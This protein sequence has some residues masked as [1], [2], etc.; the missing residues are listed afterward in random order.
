V[1]N[2]LRD[3]A[4][5]LGER[6]HPLLG[7]IFTG[8]QETPETVQACALCVGDDARPADTTLQDK[9]GHTAYVCLEHDLLLHRAVHDL[10]RIMS[11]YEAEVLAIVLQGAGRP[12]WMPWFI[13]MKLAQRAQYW[14]HVFALQVFTRHMGPLFEQHSQR[15]TEEIRQLK[16]R[17]D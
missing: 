6:I 15:V 10:D 1:R 2:S 16:N 4:L 5:T 7:P 9:H 17:K 12:L 14:I 13:Y 3:K 8:R 11:D